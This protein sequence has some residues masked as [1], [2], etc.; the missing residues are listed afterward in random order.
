MPRM[1]TDAPPEHH[2]APSASAPLNPAGSVPDGFAARG[3]GGNQTKDPNTT[4]LI[5]GVSGC[6][7][8]CTQAVWEAIM[9]KNQVI[10]IRWIGLLRMCLG[11]IA[12]NLLGQSMKAQLSSA[13]PSVGGPVGITLLLAATPRRQLPE[14]IRDQGQVHP[15][16][17]CMG[18]LLRV[19]TAGSSSS[20]KQQ[21][22]ASKWPGSSSGS[23]RLGHT[24]CAGRRQIRGACTTLLGNVWEWCNDV[25]EQYIE[26]SRVGICRFHFLGA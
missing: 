14:P 19:G 7:A 10:Q 13:F 5:A 11:T 9:G 3:M 8:P 16:D 2:P 24:R 21:V 23:T 4:C 26:K 25:Q 22:D 18:I 20:A 12:G 1:R 17:P 6:S 15:A